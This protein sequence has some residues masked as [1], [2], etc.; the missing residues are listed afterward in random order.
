[1]NKQDHKKLELADATRKNMTVKLVT[2]QSD[3]HDEGSPGRKVQMTT[4][5]NTSLAF[6][7]LEGR[8][9]ATDNLHKIIDLM[10]MSMAFFAELHL[11]LCTRPPENA[12]PNIRPSMVNSLDPL[13][14]FKRKADCIICSALS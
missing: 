8:K 7:H 14:R 3:N 13:T 4:S 2:I 12:L 5:S 9:V 1:M 6:T 11:I 10:L